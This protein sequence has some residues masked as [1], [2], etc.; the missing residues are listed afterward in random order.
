MSF[1]SIPTIFYLILNSAVTDLWKSDAFS[2]VLSFLSKNSEILCAR[3]TGG[4]LL[5]CEPQW[6]S[7]KV[8][9][10]HTS[11]PTGVVEHAGLEPAAS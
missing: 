4:V 5:G 11:H 3:I 8:A 9:G 10:I 7:P 1:C 2:Y 6:L